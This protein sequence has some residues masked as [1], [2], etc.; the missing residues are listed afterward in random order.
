MVHIA[1]LS[2]FRP[3]K[4][5]REQLRTLAKLKATAEVRIKLFLIGGVRN[6]DDEC[7]IEGLREYADSR[8]LQE[9][10]DYEFVTN[11]SVS[12]IR[13]TLKVRFLNQY[14]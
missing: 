9:G 1:S 3:E 13:D 10:V 7:L 5:H 4:N 8:Q 11:I 14:H 6:A 2:Q 12:Q